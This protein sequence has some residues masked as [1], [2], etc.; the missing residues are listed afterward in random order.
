MGYTRAKQICIFNLIIETL[1]FKEYMGCQM[2]KLAISILTVM[3]FCGQSAAGV[4]LKEVFEN[5]PAA[6]GYDRYLELET[7]VVYTGGLLIGRTNNPVDFAP[8]V[9]ET[10]LDVCIIGNGAVLDLQGEQICISFCANRLDIEDCVVINGNIR[11]RGEVQLIPDEDTTPEGTVS[12]VTFFAP[13][14]YAVR[15]QGAG[16]GVTIRRNLL[17][18]AVD[19]GWDFMVYNG[20]S[21]ENLPTGTGYSGS[22]QTGDFGYPVMTDNWSWFT[23]PEMNAIPLRHFSF[24]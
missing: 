14:D 4:A 17:V 11:Y 16:D 24:L 12:H 10:G 22:V 9:T 19:T 6:N 20:V 21:S 8:N 7:G 2:N 18:D 3:I 15:L 5:A 13:H 1:I 23:D